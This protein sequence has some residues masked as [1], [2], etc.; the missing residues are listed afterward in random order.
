MG[1]MFCEI[2]LNSDDTIS[3]ARTHTHKKRNYHHFDE[4]YA[5]LSFTIC[6]EE[7]TLLALLPENEWIF[8]RIYIVYT[9][10]LYTYTRAVLQ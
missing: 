1:K 9:L 2:A 3:H 7:A 5:N 10:K 4:F 8:R 6:R